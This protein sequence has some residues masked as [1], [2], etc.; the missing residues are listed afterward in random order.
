MAAPSNKPRPVLS[1]VWLGVVTVALI[2]LIG[3]GAIW[4]SATWAPK[5]ALDLEGGT[6]IILEPQ[7]DEDTE[8]SQ[9]QLEQA[10]AIIRQ[11]V[12]STGVSE[13]EITTQGDRNIIVNLPGNPDEETRNLVRSSAQLAFRR[14]AFVGAPEAVDQ[15]QQEEPAP[16]ETEDPA[17]DLSDEDRERLEE[18]LGDEGA[19]EGSAE[20]VP[21]G[22]G[23]VTPG[24]QTSP[25][26]AAAAEEA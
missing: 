12:D 14:V 23:A 7:V 16:E 1:F 2:V 11:R 22:G 10:V 18:L 26:A 20:D 24:A 19:A 4:S 25:Q 8:I 13:A 9:E 15:Q 6:S 17:A 5:L 21:Q 3:A